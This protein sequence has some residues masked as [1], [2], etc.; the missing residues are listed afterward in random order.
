MARQN[1][2]FDLAEAGRRTA[3]RHG[4]GLRAGQ[5]DHN[6][7]GQAGGVDEVAQNLAGFAADDRVGTK[8]TGQPERV[9]TIAANQR[10]RSRSAFQSVVSR[11]A[12]Q[13]IIAGS[14]VEQIIA[15]SADD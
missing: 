4:S 1:E 5:V 13:R 6:T 10:V 12:N 14:T 3:I 11:I 15:R 7:A 2:P 9:V 8:D